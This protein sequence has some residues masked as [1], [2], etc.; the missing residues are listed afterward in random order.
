[1]N[2]SI[3]RITLDIHRTVSP[4]S[5]RVKKGDTGRRLLINLTERGKPYHIDDDCYAVFTA[6]KPDGKV[7]LNDC[8]I[9]GC[10][11]IYDLTAQTVAVVGQLDCEIVLYG[12]DGKQLTSACFGI[13]VENTV[14]DTESEVESQSEF[15]SLAALIAELQA[16]SAY[17]IA[18]KHGYEG[19]E[20]EWVASLKGEKGD[21]GATG[22]TGPQGPQGEKGDTGATGPIGETGPQGVGISNITIREV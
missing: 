21:T 3:F 7:V 14:Y 6:L 13:I 15:N 16:K 4:V 11:I 8:T 20:E 22:A 17:E 2:A 12:V 19:T 5:L 10:E 18:V 9:D 1:M